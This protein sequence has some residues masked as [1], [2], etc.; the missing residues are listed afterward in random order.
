[1]IKTEEI[2][3]FLRE[4]K[5]FFRKIF[6][7][8]K[9]GLFGSFARGEQNENS[10]IDILIEMFE[11]TEEMFEKRMSLKNFISRHFSRNVDVCYAKAIKPMFKE[12]VFGE[13]IYV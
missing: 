10:D 1:M 5:Q 6:C 8:K 2:L 11:K 13:V 4:N 12:I 3:N 9:I 7:I